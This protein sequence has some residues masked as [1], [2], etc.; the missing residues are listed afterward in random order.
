M[1]ENDVQCEPAKSEPAESEPLK[2]T[3]LSGDE[4]KKETKSAT[5]S[6]RA[7]RKIAVNFGVKKWK[8]FDK[9]LILSTVHSWS[10]TCSEQFDR[11]LLKYSAQV[12]SFQ[13]EN[14]IWFDWIIKSW[15]LIQ[16]IFSFFVLSYSSLSHQVAGESMKIIHTKIV[17][18][19]DEKNRSFPEC[20][21]SMFLAR[22]VSLFVDFEPCHARKNLKIRWFSTFFGFLAVLSCD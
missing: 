15:F 5:K 21:W 14:M 12:D 13:I 18:S 9:Y 16:A 2:T 3:P 7:T 20:R 11:Y 4:T 8:F 10:L 22:N 17:V 6:A 1:P 19:E